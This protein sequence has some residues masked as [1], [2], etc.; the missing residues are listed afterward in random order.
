MSKINIPVLIDVIQKYGTL[1]KIPEIRVWC[2]PHHLKKQGDDYYYVFESFKDAFEFIKD[3]KPLADAIPMIAY[4]GYE[5]N[6]FDIKEIKQE[7]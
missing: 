5:I 3:N 4:N 7:K 6:I 1:C 2:H